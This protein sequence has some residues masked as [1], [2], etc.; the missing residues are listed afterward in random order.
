MENLYKKGLRLEYFTVAYNIFE[1]VLSIGF[2]SL[3]NSIALVDF[4]L[5]SIV[6]SLSGLILIWRLRKHRNLSEEEEKAIE[7]WAMKLVA[8]TFFYSWGYI[9][10]E[11]VQKLLTQEIPQPSLAGILI[12][13]ASLITMPILAWQKYRLGQNLDSRALI[14][15]SQE[16]LVCGWLSAILL[17]GLGLNYTF[18][19]WQAESHGWNC[20]RA[21]RFQRRLEN[22]GRKSTRGRLN[23]ILDWRDR[24]EKTH[25]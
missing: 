14:A 2:G 21:V 18:G 25:S 24:S 3:N 22:L 17:L 10:L 6:E 5:D 7:Q 8:A 11:S 9:L 20:D 19:F 16:T 23:M 13:I 4:G 12:A 15:D 1:A